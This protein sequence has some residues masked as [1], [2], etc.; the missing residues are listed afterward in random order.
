MGSA[1]W[2]WGRRDCEQIEER[3]NDYLT[4]ALPEGEER[5]RIT[6]HLTQCPECR[7]RVVEYTRVQ[8]AVSA[9]RSA[10]MPERAGDWRNVH[11]RLAS[12]SSERG[13]E[14][15]RPAFGGRILI[16]GLAAATLGVAAVA[17]PWGDK[18]EVVPV[19][20]APAT[21]AGNAVRRESASPGEPGSIDRMMGFATV[22][23]GKNTL[24][25]AQTFVGTTPGALVPLVIDVESERSVSKAQLE[26]H[27]QRV[28]QGG[29]S[30]RYTVS[31][32]EGSKSRF[33]VYP[34]VDID[35]VGGALQILEVTLTAPGR[36]QTL[37]LPV[38]TSTGG[39]YN[40]GYVG[41]RLG[42]ITPRL[43]FQN[44]STRGNRLFPSYVSPEYAPDKAIGYGDMQM[45]VLSPE[46]TTLSAAQWRA[47]REW[48]AMG[49][50]LV[51]TSDSLLEVP[52]LAGMAPVQKVVRN[53]F[54][55]TFTP[56]KGASEKSMKIP[57]DVVH[58][59]TTVTQRRWGMGSVFF[60][61][62]NPATEEFRTWNG[63]EEFWDTLIT[64]GRGQSL[65][66]FRM[67]AHQRS[68][69]AANSAS[70]AWDDAF[71][72][73]LPPVQFVIFLFLGYF[74]LVVPM[75][76]AVLKHTRRMNMAWVTGPVLAIVF[77]GGIFLLTARL[78]FMPTARR[79]AGILFLPSGQSAGRF[80]GNTE[81]FF[82]KA[83]RYDV[84][85]R[86]A[87]SVEM[88]LF[89][90]DR[91]SSLDSL[92]NE[93]GDTTATVSVG[94]LAF[95][96]IH[97]EQ[98]VDVPG[99]I[100]VELQL[101]KDDLHKADVNREAEF[102]GFVENNTG[103]PLLNTALS[104]RISVPVKRFN[105]PT[106]YARETRVYSL[107]TL[108]P[109]RT[110]IH[111]DPAKWAAYNQ[112]NSLNYS[113]GMSGYYYDQYN[114]VIPA[115]MAFMAQTSGTTFGPEIGRDFSGEQSVTIVVGA[116]V[117]KAGGK[118]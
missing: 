64:M 99:T 116:N 37:R 33:L 102:V 104:C 23:T 31:L 8:E 27:P 113:I 29:R 24:A 81:L 107:G 50:Q 30:Y 103:K 34:M 56:V 90:Q 25:A 80:A 63:C 45:L 70:G 4:G 100:T 110:A 115:S 36:K 89:P 43:Q 105:K 79:T 49:G 98:S 26:V 61:E 101:K 12:S 5:T 85:I 53:A 52:A 65:R 84:P 21:Q 13:T 96:R 46:A 114:Y 93:A 14:A 112:T 111:T 108:P 6:A 10:P 76:F 3:L 72:L 86:R 55:T 20:A 35:S 15:R 118:Q 38:Q 88:K 11:A 69:T 77:A 28:S 74:V 83:G 58:Q 94:N 95:R 60:T 48:V 17:F 75:T 39:L 41:N 73:T 71:R 44:S 68:V 106:F 78:Y 66:D 42:A 2:S 59:S 9:Y 16:P 82:P 1:F 57:A 54:G 47:I 91:G 92:E 19:Q 87:D 22:G 7:A 97:H 40:L 18:S 51:L 62:F 109:G 32:T 67:A 117:Q